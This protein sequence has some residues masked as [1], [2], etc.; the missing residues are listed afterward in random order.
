MSA[1]GGFCAR[2]LAWLELLLVSKMAD[3]PQTSRECI[4]LCHVMVLCTFVNPFC[5]KTCRDVQSCVKA[6]EHD[7]AEAIGSVLSFR[8]YVCLSL[9]LSILMYLYMYVC[10]HA[11]LSVCVYH[12]VLSFYICVCLLACVYLCLGLK[13]PSELAEALL[14]W[15]D[16]DFSESW[17]FWVGC[18][19]AE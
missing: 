13:R 1:H 5:L 8:F 12:C 15:F 18:C 19:T 10:R 3:I 9:C 6:F 2:D 14:S 7:H 4:R 16:A 17:P 11:C